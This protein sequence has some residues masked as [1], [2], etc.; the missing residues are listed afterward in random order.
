MLP[1]YIT[2]KKLHS[3]IS[4]AFTEDLGDGDH[5]SLGSI[6][7]SKSNTAHLLI[8]DL[9]IIAGLE[10]SKY[11]FD[12]VSKDFK[13]DYLLKDGDEVSPGMVAFSIEGNAQQ[14]L[15]TERLALNCLQRMSGIA[16]RTRQLNELIKG[17][18]TRLLDTRKTTPNF[19]LAEKWA[20]LI[21]GGVN[22]RF[23]LF[24]MVMLKDNHID[25]AGGV[26]PALVAIKAYLEK[27]NKPLKIEI[28]IR[29]LRELKEAIDFGGFHRILLD[30]MSISDLRECV[31]LIDGRY[32][33]EASGGITQDNIRLV[34]ETGV[35]FISVGALTHSYKSLDLS[36]KVVN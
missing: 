26:K 20:V 29:D 1:E 18:G 21:G 3:F 13:I 6:P 8:K 14:I 30:N 24:D 15:G 5:S 9:G 34:A 27:I 12:F 28:E 11:I 22:H 31:A 23:G 7:S 2:Q 4:A 19:R 16:T 32:E 10:L 35:D 17:T 25:V 33:I 36:L